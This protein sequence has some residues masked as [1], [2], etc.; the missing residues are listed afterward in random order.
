MSLSRTQTHQEKKKRSISNWSS[1]PSVYTNTQKREV[2]KDGNMW[3]ETLLG[4]PWYQINAYG[5]MP[6]GQR[7]SAHFYLEITV[8]TWEKLCQYSNMGN[9]T[10]RIG[11]LQEA[12]F[13]W[14]FS[15]LITVSFEWSFVNP[16]WILK[17]TS[18]WVHAIVFV[19]KFLRTHKPTGQTWLDG[20]GRNFFFIQASCA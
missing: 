4:W 12:V 5:T 10:V 16:V 19:K 17:S 8:I 6:R 13:W 2:C 15:R 9:S 3:A 11:A 7:Q 1:S 18:V 14:V 20:H